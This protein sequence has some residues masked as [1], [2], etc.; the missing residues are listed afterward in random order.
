MG[1]IPRVR[2]KSLS[3]SVVLDFGSR[4]AVAGVLSKEVS[5][6]EG[7]SSLDGKYKLPPGVAG[8][9]FSERVRVVSSAWIN[10]FNCFIP[11]GS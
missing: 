2:K 4:F 5:S 6:E 7:D 1:L 8:V 11:H 9:L 10:N 3:G